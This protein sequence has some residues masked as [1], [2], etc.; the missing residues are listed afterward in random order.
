MKTRQ[1]N[2]LATLR[3][4]TILKDRKSPLI[5]EVELVV[6][7][8]QLPL[9]IREAIIDELG[10]EFAEKGLGSDSEP[11]KY[12]LEIEELTDICSQGST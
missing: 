11:N 8:A 9:Y 5:Q 2:V 6:D 7:V 1:K 12:G 4:G 3:I 10:D